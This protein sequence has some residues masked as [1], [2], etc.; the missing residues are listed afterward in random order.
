MSADQTPQFWSTVHRLCNGH[1]VLRKMFEC[2]DPKPHRPGTNKVL[3]AL[4]WE[5]DHPGEEKPWNVVNWDFGT[6]VGVWGG[7]C[8]CPE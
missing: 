8:T 2:T 1:D 6:P 5:N 3:Y 4:E 7:W